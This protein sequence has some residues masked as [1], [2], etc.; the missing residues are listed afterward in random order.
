MLLPLP[1]LAGGG[2]EVGAHPG[3]SHAGKNAMLP[4][5]ASFEEVGLTRRLLS[6][7]WE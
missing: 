5:K 4:T 2:G 3:P 7:K 6:E 1:G